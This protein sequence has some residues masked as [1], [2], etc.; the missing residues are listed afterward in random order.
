M[1]T[2]VNPLVSLLVANYNGNPYV[3]ETLESIRKQT[4]SNIELFV[5]D[6]CSTDSSSATIRS[7]IEKNMHNA[8]FV[9]NASNIGGGQTKLKAIDMAKGEI[10][11]FVDCDDYLEYNAIEEMVKAHLAH[12]EV[13]LV[14]SEAYK[15]DSQGSVIGLLGK[16]KEIKSTSTILE[17]CSAF[18][19]ATWKKVFYDKCQ[20]GFNGNYNVAYDLDLYFKLEEVSDVLFINAPLYYY[21]V[22][23]GNLSIGMD[24]TGLSLT[25]LMLA[26]Y[27]AQIRRGKLN[28]KELGLD[29]QSVLNS[30]YIKGQNS[31]SWKSLTMKNLKKL[32]K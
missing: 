15:V 16:A 10:I 12:P 13:G 5:I 30:T 18:H 28:I 19:L 26:K 23:G 32:I 8:I 9:Q 14:Y 17:T 24:R 7:Y 31:V 29:L 11:A 22:H 4:Y 1:E 21:R 27:E 20:E 2:K 6:D 25:E 3:K